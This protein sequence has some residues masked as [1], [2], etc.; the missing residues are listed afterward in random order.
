[1]SQQQ[2]ILEYL[3]DGE[4][5]CM[6]NANFYMK[7]D[8]KRISELREQGHVILSQPCDGRCGVKHN[9]RLL[10]RKLYGN[11]N[12]EVPTR[13]FSL[14]RDT[15]KEIWQTESDGNT[16]FQ[17]REEIQPPKVEVLQTLW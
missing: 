17:P 4:W 13:D 6:A 2:Q 15:R 10:M 16:G 9:S 11:K 14:P 5:H 3:S 12:Q 1:M 7:D 8:R